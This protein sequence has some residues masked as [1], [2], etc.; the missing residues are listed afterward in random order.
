M[1]TKALLKDPEPTT[2]IERQVSFASRSVLY[3]D[4]VVA[5]PEDGILPPLSTILDYPRDAVPTQS[6]TANLR[7]HWLPPRKSLWAARS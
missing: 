1:A 3:L 4:Q 6:S 7:Y 5:R 2:A